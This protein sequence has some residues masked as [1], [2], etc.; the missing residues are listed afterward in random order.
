MLQKIL[1]EAND[2]LGGG[3][4][5]EV[6]KS[7]TIRVFF[8]VSGTLFLALGVVGILLPILPTTPFL[9]L[10]AAC[11]YKGSKRMHQWIL[12]NRWFGDYIKNYREGRGISLK[13]KFSAIVLLWITISYSAI[14]VVPILIVQIVLLIV[15][16]AVSVHVITLPTFRKT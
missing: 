1:R 2:N 16:V 7:K 3:S 4:T 6:V 15:A 10:A 11:Y 5:P 12:N 14:F 13:A 8:I 9:L